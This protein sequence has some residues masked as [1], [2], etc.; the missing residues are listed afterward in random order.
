M[1]DMRT[2]RALT[3]A[4]RRLFASDALTWHCHAVASPLALYF[5]ETLAL[6]G[7]AQDIVGGRPHY[8]AP[9]EWAESRDWSGFLS[10]LTDAQVV[11]AEHD[12]GVW[13]AACAEAPASLRALGRRATAIVE[14]YEFSGESTTAPKARRHVKKRKSAQLHALCTVAALRFEGVERIIDLGSGHGHLTRALALTLRPHETLGVDWDDARI[15]R[16]IDL[17]AASPDDAPVD[18][19]RFVHGDASRADAG[20]HRDDVKTRDLVTGLHPCGALGDALVTRARTAGAHVLA[21]SCC[22]QKT[23]SA[24]RRPL[25]EQGRAANFVVPREAL[26]LANLS[27]RSFDG[28]GTL[29]VKRTGR[30]TRLALRLALEARGLVLEQGA[31][32][33]G[34]SKGRVRHGLSVI[35]PGAFAAR[36]LSAP[37]ND[38]LDLAEARAISA[39]A[40][41]ARFALPRHALS[42]P[43]EVAIVLDRARYLEEAG[44]RTDVVTLFPPGTSPRNLGIV[45]NAPT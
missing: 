8:D 45:A 9:P 21:V 33:N 40:H 3:V 27:P 37:T 36:G 2:R 12:P 14:R 13:L 31:E 16:A 44:W 5:E 30:R 20:A 22:Y 42:R 11:E 15:A 1:G 7:E 28:S 41:V 6:L 19:P 35:A 32:G 43:L 34:I 25:S 24:Y 23:D 39:H 29:D 17:S 26:G 18:A 4:R 10:R 38:E